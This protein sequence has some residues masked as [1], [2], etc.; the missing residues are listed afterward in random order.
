MSVYFYLTLVSLHKF[1]YTYNYIFVARI[2]KAI[3]DWQS[4]DEKFV[5]TNSSKQLYKCLK[6]NNFVSV[7]GSAGIGKS[8]TSRH[9]ALQMMLEGY[10][11]IPVKSPSEIFVS[12]NKTL[13][14]YMTTFVAGMKLFSMK[15][16]IGIDILTSF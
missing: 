15:S 13:Y 4:V 3:T 16:K 14:I 8:I 11:V 1:M 2:K 9:V 6:E 5:E 7:T 12:K 10:D